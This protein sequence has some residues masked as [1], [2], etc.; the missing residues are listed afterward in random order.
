MA[1]NPNSINIEDLKKLSASIAENPLI[2]KN[3]F[4]DK[5]HGAMRAKK[6]QV[7]S[8]E[9][10]NVDLPDVTIQVNDVAV[11]DESSIVIPNDNI[12][13]LFGVALPIQTLYLTIVIILVGACIWWFMC[14]ESKPK[15]RKNDELD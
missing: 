3:A 11:P 8:P 6:V 7:I 4:G 13:N 2:N 1:Q 10:N 12:I 15:T 9:S 14:T 5:S